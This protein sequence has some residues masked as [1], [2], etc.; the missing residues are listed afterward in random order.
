MSV[1]KPKSSPYWHYD[2]KLKGLRFYGSTGTKSK[3]E[4]RQIEA[5]ERTRAATA[6][7]RRQRLPMTLNAAAGRYFME[8]AERQPSAATTEYQLA[9][10]I[11]GLGVETLLADLT[12][13]EIAIYIARRRAAVSDASVNRETQLLKRVFRRAETVWKADTGCRISS[14]SLAACWLAALPPCERVH[15]GEPAIRQR[16]M[17]WLDSHP[18]RCPV[19]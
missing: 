15:G 12:D 8:V 5:R 9:N 19:L 1:Y 2:F 17:A 13:N 7:G 4:A 3:A 10:L 6:G 14:P 16:Q 11:E 18:H